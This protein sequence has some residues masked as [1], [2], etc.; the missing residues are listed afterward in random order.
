MHA[1][2]NHFTR[3][4]LRSLLTRAGHT[5]TRIVHRDMQN[6]AAWRLSFNSMDLIII[7]RSTD[8]G[9]FD[10]LGE[11]QFFADLTKPILINTGYILRDNRLGFTT[12]NTIPDS[13]TAFRL[14]TEVPAHPIFTGVGLDANGLM[15]SNFNVPPISYRGITQLGISVNTDAIDGGGT[16][17]AHIGATDPT[18]SGTGMVIAEWNAGATLNP[19]IGPRRLRPSA[20]CSSLAAVKPAASPDKARACSTWRPSARCYTSTR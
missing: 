4:R 5:V 17:L 8:G 11:A 19:A 15:T 18:N 20:W 2:G 16:L 9:F 13:N 7:G 6:T 1:T 14:K 12:G 3:Q 10:T